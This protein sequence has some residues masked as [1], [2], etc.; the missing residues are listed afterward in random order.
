M[1]STPSRSSR[2]ADPGRKRKREL[3]GHQDVRGS[4]SPKSTLSDTLKRAGLPLPP[5]RRSWVEGQVK[6]LCSL[7]QHLHD[8]DQ[9][10]N[11]VGGREEGGGEGGSVR[12]FHAHTTSLPTMIM[13]DSMKRKRP[14]GI[15]MTRLG[16][17]STPGSWVSDG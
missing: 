11:Q 16:I 6:S 2:V 9:T 15:G 17:L 12:H 7:V 8:L 10:L 13:D 1:K 3:G 14:I 5:A 4:T